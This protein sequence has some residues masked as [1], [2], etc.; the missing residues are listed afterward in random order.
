VPG[1]GHGSPTVVGDQVLLAV[2]DQERGTQS[3]FCYHRRTGSLLWQT[4]VHHGGLDSKGNAK[5]SLASA[6]VACDGHRLFINFF[7]S[8]AIYATA[9]NREGKQLWQTKVTDF[10]VHQGFGSS[11][12]LYGPFVIVSA[13][14]KGGGVIAALERSTG[15]LMWKQDRP[16]LPNYTSPMILESAGR[17]QL[18]LIGCELISSFDPLTGKKFWEI[19]GATTECVTSV[20][21]DGQLIFSTGG[22]PRNHVAAVRADGSGAIVWDKNTRVYVPSLLV[23][24]GH[25]YG[26]LDNGFAVC[27]ECQSGKECWKGRLGGTF[28]ASPV[29]VGENVYST[30]ESGRTFV[31]K[32]SPSAFELVAENQLGDEVLASPAICGSRVYMRV[33]V[34]RNGVR[35]ETLYCLGKGK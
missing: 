30:N 11:P 10:V 16:R 6:T 4:D 31:F 2:A 21:T 32:A 24:A 3:V 19:Q 34:H 17:P 28:S 15:K 18:F 27:W 12:A 22:Y 33:A 1:R 5:S 20:V 13:D 14:H 8:G 35:Q 26:A 25:L 23:H 29:L 9:L 7:N